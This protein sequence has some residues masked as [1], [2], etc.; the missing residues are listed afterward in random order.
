MKFLSFFE[1]EIAAEMLA[2]Y[3]GAVEDERV[4]CKVVDRKRVGPLLGTRLDKRAEPIGKEP[5]KVLD[6]GVG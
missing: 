3:I 5:S 6:W 1:S 4:D 2:L